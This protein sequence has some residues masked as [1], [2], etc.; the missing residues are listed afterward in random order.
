MLKVIGFTKVWAYFIV[1]IIY[2]NYIYKYNF[3]FE[4]N[5]L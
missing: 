4:C 2:I 5:I 3:I 1:L